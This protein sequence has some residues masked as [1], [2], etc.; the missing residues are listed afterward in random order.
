MKKPLLLTSFGLLAH[1][2]AHAQALTGTVT[3]GGASPSYPTL[4]A[5]V[6]DL[7]TRGVGAGGLTVAVRPGTYA[8]RI[9]LTTLAGSSAANPVRFV[10]RGGTATLRP[11]GTSAAAEA[12]VTLT[13]CD[14]ITFDS[15]NVADGGTAAADQ[16]EVGY[17]LTGTATKGSTHVTVSN[18]AVRLGGGPAPAAAVGTRG[19]WAVSAATTTGST[20]DF[21]RV[22]NVRVDRASIGIQLAGRANLSGLPTFPDQGNEVRGCVLGGQRF[23]GLDGANG[24]ALGIAVGSQRR[25]NLLDNRIDSVLVRNGAPIFPVNSRR[26]QPRQ[27]QRAHCRQPHRLR[28]LRRH[29][30]VA[31]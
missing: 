9:A 20:N 26:H 21:N 18:C 5:A 1:T 30:R 16:I 27:R 24:S 13:A 29:G 25:L 22:L 17:Y 2:A 31:G 3:V 6:A 23:I 15:L 19:V 12:A 14:Y 8:E 10:G 4:T 7:Q 28:A 11:V